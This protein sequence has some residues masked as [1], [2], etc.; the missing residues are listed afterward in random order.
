MK[1][2]KIPI[3]ETHKLPS[4]GN[5]YA[6]GIKVPEEVTL[7][8]MSTMDEKIRLSSIGINV[9][10]NILEACIVEP[11]DFNVNLLKVP[12]VTFLMY[13]LRILTYGP[14]YKYPIMC[15]DCG[16]VSTIEFSLDEI[17]VSYVTESFKEPFNIGPLPISGDILQVKILSVGDFKAI[18]KEAKKM[19]EK[20]PEYVGDPEFILN[21]TFKIVTINNEELAPFQ[22]NKYIE[23][24][25]ARDLNYF[26]NKY[27]KLLTDF[28]MDL[29]VSAPC[30]HCG[31]SVKFTLSITDEFFRPS[32][33]ND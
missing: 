32:D 3:Q 31:E 1:A 28:G 8:A 12:D 2:R 22:L 15:G 26:D 17:P 19:L 25:H 7:R 30:K 11:K 20:F 23:S 6:E 16:K 24:L 29:N 33:S 13:K 21:R 9:M 27:D 14:E 18:E 4:A 10:P 5:V